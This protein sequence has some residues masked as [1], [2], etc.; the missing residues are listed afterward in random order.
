MSSSNKDKVFIDLVALMDMLIAPPFESNVPDNALF[1]LQDIEKCPTAM[2][3]YINDTITDENRS[4]VI[5]HL[6]KAI[7]S[8][9]RTTRIIGVM[10]F[11]KLFHHA[12]LLEKSPTMDILRALA[13][14]IHSTDDVEAYFAIKALGNAT[15]GA[16]REVEILKDIIID[17]YLRR[18]CG[19]VQLE[20]SIQILKAVSKYFRLLRRS[21]LGSIFDRIASC[22]T[23]YVDHPH[24][25]IQAGYFELFADL[26]QNY[27]QKM[28]GGF[29]KYVKEFLPELLVKL[30]SKDPQLKASAVAALLHSLPHIRCQNAE[31]LLNDDRR[32]ISKLYEQLGQEESAFLVTMKLIKRSMYIL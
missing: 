26:A 31:Q 22:C 24:P 3:I 17:S 27:V 30:H 12:E 1:D 4:K 11:S 7:T 9:S 25:L 32:N 5:H 13:E 16:P 2:S 14:K 8:P 20:V 29:K 28:C 15:K 6:L 10:F 23:N 18:L 21:T 19:R